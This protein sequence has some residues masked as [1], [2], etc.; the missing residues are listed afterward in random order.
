MSAELKAGDHVLTNHVGAYERDW[1]QPGTVVLCE[2]NGID[3]VR[4]A[5]GL[6]TFCA[7]ELRR[8]PGAN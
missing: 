4:M 6:H 5:D 7:Y 1:N 8:D 3:E 2:A